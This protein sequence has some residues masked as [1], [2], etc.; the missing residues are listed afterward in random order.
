MQN[1]ATI[2]LLVVFGEVPEHIES[3]AYGSVCYGSVCYG[4]VCYGL[5]MTT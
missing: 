2:L 1:Y 3:L 5:E 4:S